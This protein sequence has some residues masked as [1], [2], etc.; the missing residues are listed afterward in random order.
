MRYVVNYQA[1]RGISLF[2][3]MA[4][5]YDRKSAMSLQFRP[6]FIGENPGMDCLRQ[7]N[8]YT[9]RLS[10]LLQESKAEISTALYYPFRT[11]CAGGERGAEAI[12]SFEEIGHL[13]EQKGICFDLID[14]DFVRSAAVSQGHL[15]GEYV[16]YDNVFVPE[17]VM[18]KEEVIEKLKHVGHRSVPCIQRQN[19]FIASR[20]LLF[21]DGSEG[22][23]IC[24]TSVHI[25]IS[26]IRY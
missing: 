9:G 26:T 25:L 13:L 3:F 22:Y 20:K 23:F 1:V 16:T 8:E 17:A 21:A 15:V 2:N 19:P 5:S 14:E 7:I 4:L 10:H 12:H 18:E 24:N 6:N 11:I